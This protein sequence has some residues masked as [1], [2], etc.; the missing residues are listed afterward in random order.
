MSRLTV[1]RLIAGYGRPSVCIIGHSRRRAAGST[2]AAVW[3]GASRAARASRR[4]WDH[5]A[6]P[7]SDRVVLGAAGVLRQRGAIVARRAAGKHS[8][9][10]AGPGATGPGGARGRGRARPR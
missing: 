3:D 6:E 1:R 5:G 9:W 4:R 7:A 2:G 8:A 10:L